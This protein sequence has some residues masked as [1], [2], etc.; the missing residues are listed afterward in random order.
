MSVESPRRPGSAEQCPHNVIRLREGLSFVSVVF[1]CMRVVLSLTGIFTV[2]E[3]HPPSDATAGGE[4]SAEPGWHNALDGTD[5]WDA[6]WF[7]RI[8][9][10]GY[11]QDDSSAAF[12]PG[13]PLA[14]RGL[15]NLT[16]LDASMAG[17]LVSNVAF[18]GSLIVLY[19]LTAREYDRAHARRTVVLLAAFPSSFFFL[20]PYSESLFLLSALLGFWW[21]RSDGWARAGAAG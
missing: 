21:A 2:G 15:M 17:V 8:A 3:V 5:R 13:Y 7:E 1:V 16:S 4:V 10:E 20:A 18:L 6:V 11:A 12:F 9:V 19:G 14:I